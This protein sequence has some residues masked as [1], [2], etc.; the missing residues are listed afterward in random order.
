[1]CHLVMSKEHLP[2]LNHDLLLEIQNRADLETA[3]A[4]S[5]AIRGMKRIRHQRLVKIIEKGHT[6]ERCDDDAD[7]EFDQHPFNYK[8]FIEFD[9]GCGVYVQA[10]Y[11][12]QVPRCKRHIKKQ[13]A[14]GFKFITFVGKYTFEFWLLDDDM[15]SGCIRFIDSRL[16]KKTFLPDMLNGVI[17]CIEHLQGTEFKDNWGNDHFVQFKALEN[18]EWKEIIKTTKF[19]SKNQ[20]PSKSFLF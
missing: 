14:Y 17:A 18:P 3:I 13:Y 7:D 15:Q 16:N 19:K 4:M 12:V 11:F 6:F 5:I 20:V 2:Q 10:T 1:M 9:D 8:H